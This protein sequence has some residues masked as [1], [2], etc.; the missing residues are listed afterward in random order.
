M[1]ACTE[2]SK[3]EKVCVCKRGGDIVGFFFSF[4]VYIPGNC[5]AVLLNN[6]T[7]CVYVYT[8]RPQNLCLIRVKNA[9]ELIEICR[10]GSC[11]EFG[12][13]TLTKWK[14]RLNSQ[15]ILTL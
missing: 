4:S 3:W 15:I 10:L 11:Q 12:G 5:S 6:E 14:S 8:H 1:P 13:Q 9:A 2:C 7:V